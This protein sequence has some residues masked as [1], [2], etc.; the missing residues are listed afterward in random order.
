MQVAALLDRARLGD[1]GALVLHGEAGL[2]KTVLLE[3]VLGS[4]EDARILRAAGAEFE[5]ELSFTALHQLCLPLLELIGR[6]PAPQGR[7]L[8]IAFGLEAGPAPDQFLIGLALLSLLSEAATHGPVICVLDDAQWLDSGSAQALAFVARRI[9]A[10]PLALL[11]ATRDPDAAP[12]LA[13]LPRL[14]L[15]PL[16]D[17]A[18]RTLLT[19]RAPL[20]AEIRRQLVAEARGNPLALWELPRSHG[21]A[22]FPGTP[23]QPVPD[24]IERRFRE[25]L[26]VL[27]ERTQRLLVIAAAESLGIPEVLEHAA[28]L[29]DLTLADA[30]P[31]ES[32]GL[33]EIDFRVR[34]RHPLVRSAIYRLASE[35]DRRRAH[36][37]LAQAFDVDGHHD[38]RT[39][40]L[41]QA[42]PHAD[43]QLALHLEQEADNARRRG[44]VAAA[45]AFLERSVELTPDPAKRAERAVIAAHAKHESG[46]S[47]HTGT[48]LVL[49][50]LGPLTDYWRARLLRLRGQIAFALQRDDT[51]PMWLLEAAEQAAAL[52]P[53]LA[54]ETYLEALWAATGA[55][56]HGNAQG[57]RAVAATIRRGPAAPAVP[58]ASDHLL[59]GLAALFTEGQSTAAPLLRAAVEMLD[60]ATDP[61]WLPVACRAAWD[62]WDE[63]ALENL[64]T[65]CVQLTRAAGMVSLLPLALNFQAVA[66]TYNGRFAEA[67]AMTEEAHAITE[68]MAGASSPYAAIVLAA[69]QGDARRAGELFDLS[70]RAAAAGQGGF[71]TIVEYATAVLH[72]GRG[73]HQAALLPARQA[74]SRS[75][76]FWSAA[77]LPELVEAAVRTGETRLAGSA[78]E[79]LAELTEASGTHWGLGVLARSRA[80]LCGAPDELYQE[81]L[82]RLGRSRVS[83]QLARTHLLYGEWLSRAEHREQARAQLRKAHGMF[84]SMGATGFATRAARE[85][86]HLGEYPT[87]TTK[88]AIDALTSREAHIARLVAG[89]RTSKEVAAELFLSPRT[90]EAHLRNVFQKLGI[91]SRRQLRDMDLRA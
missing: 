17:E 28:G 8:R 45:A 50:D 31:A 62:L 20:D 29:D 23:D 55:E 73:D 52:D 54:R 88:S 81:A 71:V 30:E 89:G 37:V 85:L 26:S 15:A 16:T 6:I 77:A 47:E 33:L 63:K 49:A 58:L 27:P 56:R 35:T 87:R 36:H 68:A 82:A 22:G 3:T 64:A 34:F 65:R 5:R 57:I 84:D 51:A 43:E 7:A 39:W 75:R 48:L 24:L 40:H 19:L 72:N 60:G 83:V 12:A 69:F 78:V 66:A 79:E 32:A 11:I 59:D 4:A 14:A 42:A 9:Q 46:A 38:R 1:G 41:A 18:A 2:G 61:R 76:L 21:P 74:G 53:A 44:G 80:L 67:T 86:R 90:I 25:R 10:D 13:V 70:L 91:T